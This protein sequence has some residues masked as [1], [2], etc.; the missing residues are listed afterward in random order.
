MTTYNTQIIKR[1]YPWSDTVSGIKVTFRLMNQDDRDA[2]VTF[3]NRQTAVDR[4]FLRLNIADPEVVDEWLSNID[5]GRT[6]TVIAESEHRV[7]GYSSL[8][9]DETLWTSHM[10]EL[11]IFVDRQYR[12]NGIGEV[13]AGEM[14]HVAH[15]MRLER[16]VC[17]VPAE[18]DRVRVMFEALGFQPEAILDD[19]IQTPDGTLHDLMVLSKYLRP[20]GA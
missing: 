1:T 9:H 8:H 14:F 4:A 16:I 19:W 20:F 2:I 7:L 15:E 5:K 3:A 17:Q 12:A 13:L 11:R 10:G 18:Q 6:V